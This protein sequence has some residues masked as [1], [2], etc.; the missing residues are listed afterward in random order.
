[1]TEKEQK[2]YDKLFKS[3][4]E[5]NDVNTRLDLLAQAVSP[6]TGAIEIGRA[7]V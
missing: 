7:H 6:I 2:N 1:M 3:L 4:T 5:M